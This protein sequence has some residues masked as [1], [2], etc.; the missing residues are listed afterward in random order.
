M[1]LAQSVNLGSEAYLKETRFG[2]SP[3]GSNVSYQLTHTESSFNVCIDISSASREKKYPAIN[4]SQVSLKRLGS[5]SDDNGDGNENI[6]S[7]YKCA[8]F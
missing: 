8:L 7:K 3:V 1:G 5:L 4:L 6:I 2:H